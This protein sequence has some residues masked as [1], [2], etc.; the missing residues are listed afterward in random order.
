MERTRFLRFVV[1]GGL[2]ALVNLAS[3]YLLNFFMSFAVAVAVAYLFGM[4]TAYV[5]GRIFVFERSGR[6]V[7]TNFG[8]SR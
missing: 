1:T 3:R 5:L 7:A 6:T 2:A 4:T 8:A